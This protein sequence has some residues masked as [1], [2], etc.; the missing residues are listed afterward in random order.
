MPV[1]T[2]DAPPPRY[3]EK[4]RAPAA[5]SRITTHQRRRQNSAGSGSRWGN[6][7]IR[8]P[9]DMCGTGPV[10]A[11]RPDNFRY[12]SRSRRRCRQ[13]RGIEWGALAE[14]NFVTNASRPP[15]RVD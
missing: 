11:N 15:P 13:V 3:V 2:S 8:R 7:P 14:S 4:T 6:Q 1:P 10:D 5:S 9:S 12:S